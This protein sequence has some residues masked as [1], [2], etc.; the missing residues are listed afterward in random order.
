MCSSMDS[1]PVH[2][3]MMNIVIINKMQI[4][5]FQNSFEKGIMFP[6]NKIRNISFWE[7]NSVAMLEARVS[8]RY[9]LWMEEEKK[10]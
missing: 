6:T 4:K 10:E 3:R 8:T 1:K 2:K 5:L 7:V 9:G